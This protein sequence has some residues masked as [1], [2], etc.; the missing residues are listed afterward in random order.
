MQRKKVSRKI[1]VPF[2]RGTQI[3]LQKLIF[4]FS[5]LQIITA[6]SRRNLPKTKKKREKNAVQR[7]E[8]TRKTYGKL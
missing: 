8:R 5:K 1:V 7:A 3:V 4:I 2:G 6:I